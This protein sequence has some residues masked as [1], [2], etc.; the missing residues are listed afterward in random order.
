MFV[1]NMRIGE[2]C[3]QVKWVQ[4]WWIMEIFKFM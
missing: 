4:L 2:G 1:I 3:G